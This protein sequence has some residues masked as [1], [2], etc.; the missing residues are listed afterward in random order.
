MK[1]TTTK[2]HHTNQTNTSLHVEKK[3]QAVCLESFKA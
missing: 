1:Q 3:A 2:K